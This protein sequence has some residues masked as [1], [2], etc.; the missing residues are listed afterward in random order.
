MIRDNNDKKSRKI[1]TVI[2][3]I[4]IT[5]LVISIYAM[6]AMAGTDDVQKDDIELNISDVSEESTEEKTVSGI[7]MTD[8]SDIVNQVLP[9]VVSITSRTVVESYISSY[10]SMD[11]LMDYINGIGGFGDLFRQYY[12]NGYSNRSQAYGDSQGSRNGYGS[13]NPY[14]DSDSSSEQEDTDEEDSE[15]EEE[16]NEVESGIG[17]GTIIARTDDELIILT[18]A[19]VVEDCSSLYVTFINDDT[20]EGNV[21]AMDEDKDIAIVSIPIENIAEETLAEI[22]VATLASENPQMGEGVAV[23]GN[24]LGY[25]I[26]VTSGIISATDREMTFEGKTNKLLQTDA[27]INSG[28]SGGCMINGRGEVVGINEGKVVGSY[29]ESMCYA[30]PVASNLDTIMALA[31]SSSTDDYEAE[32]TAHEAYIGITGTD[33]SDELIQMGFPQGVYVVQTTEGYGAWDAGI[34]SGDIITKLGDEEILTMEELQSELKNYKAGDTAEV[35]VNRLIDGEYTEQ[36]IT[37]VL[38]GKIETEE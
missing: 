15:A 24:A 27:V 14:G 20:A 33:V 21:K 5:A 7:Y 26:S 6:S 3:I 17:T 2:S 28:N 37:V 32:L 34:R 11:D 30:I 18:C 4:V 19:H 31:N 1:T 9:S 16:L 13:S 38:S 25:G 10:G 23:I 29:V 35:T 8:I 36:V 12:G 22:K